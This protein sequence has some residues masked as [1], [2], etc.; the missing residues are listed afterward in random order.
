MG[1]HGWDLASSTV[2]NNFTDKNTYCKDQEWGEVK[3]KIF[4]GFSVAS[5]KLVINSLFVHHVWWWVLLSFVRK[6]VPPRQWSLGFFCPNRNMKMTR[7]VA[8]KTSETQMTWEWSHLFDWW[9]RIG[10][11]RKEMGIKEIVKMMKSEFRFMFW[12]SFSWLMIWWPGGLYLLHL[13][14]LLKIGTIYDREFVIPRMF[15]NKEFV[16]LILECANEQYFQVIFFFGVN[17]SLELC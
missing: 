3:E 14:N 12:G 11:H 2:S 9:W 8:D 10:C 1:P 7:N 6:G 17:L 16:N 4:S 15:V 5:S 13:N